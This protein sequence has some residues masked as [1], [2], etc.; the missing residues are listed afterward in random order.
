MICLRFG[1]VLLRAGFL[2]GLSWVTV[3]DPASYLSWTADRGLQPPGIL[4][5]VPV[6]CEHHPEE[7]PEQLQPGQA[8]DIVPELTTFEE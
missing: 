2:L 1:V 6:V 5:L 7:H 4:E 3:K 8:L